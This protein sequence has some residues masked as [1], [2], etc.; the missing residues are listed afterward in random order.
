MKKLRFG[1]LLMLS[2]SLCFLVSSCEDS[3]NPEPAKPLKTGILLPI[4]AAADSKG[5][6]DGKA[7][8][9]RLV[10]DGYECEV[11]YSGG[12][13]ATERSE[14]AR[15]VSSGVKVLLLSHAKDSESAATVKIA[16]DAGMKVICYDRLARNTAD[17][18]FFVNYDNIMIGELMGE[19]LVK[20]VTAGTTANPLYLYTGADWDYNAIWFFRGSWSVLQPKIKD[21]TFTFKNSLK[22]GE[23]KDIA[24]LTDAQV[25]EIIA[26]TTTNW[27]YDTAA[28]LAETNL[29]SQTGIGTVY[30]LAPNDQAALAVAPKF[31]AHGGTPVITGQD[32]MTAA[33]NAVI[34]GT[35]AMTV[36]KPLV[37]QYNAAVT[38]MKFFA[39][40]KTPSRA[41][42]KTVNNGSADIPALYAAPVLIDSK[43]DIVDAIAAGDIDAT[44]LSLP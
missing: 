1:R 37:R 27:N 12:D 15:L 3:P 23:Y 34:A 5:A 19:C 16:K 4:S 20:A 38:M 13:V 24:S 9:D 14:L 18:D 36:L 21:D 29:G 7:L 41:D 25:L 10:A 28:A 8:A 42:Y 44:G 32:G 26:E 22:A 35:Q 40:G 2:V 43:Q 17:V 30:V 39:D 33:L 6:Y 11:A 31:R